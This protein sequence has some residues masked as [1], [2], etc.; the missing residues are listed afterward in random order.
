[1]KQQQ[2][3]SIIEAQYITKLTIIE[4]FVN[5]CVTSSLTSNTRRFEIRKSQ[6]RTTIDFLIFSFFTI[7]FIWTTICLSCLHYDDNYIE[8]LNDFRVSR[9]WT[10]LRTVNIM[11]SMTEKRWEKTIKAKK[12]CESLHSWISIWDEERRRDEI[13]WRRRRWRIWKK[14]KVER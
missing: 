7:F 12:C 1:M 5:Y 9:T 14:S 8:F 2:R 11:T 6:E 4:R 10:S 3:D 13:E